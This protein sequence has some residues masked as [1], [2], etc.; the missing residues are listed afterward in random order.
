MGWKV[1]TA[2]RSTAQHSTGQH[3]WQPPAHAS[4]PF[5]P[6][7]H[8]HTHTHHNHNHWQGLR[9]LL[10]VHPSAPLFIAGHSLGGALATLCAVDVR[11][12][13]AAPDV[14]LFTFGSPRVGN[15]VFAAW[16]EQQTTVCIR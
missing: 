2:L 1:C 9:Y 13:L 4:P 5:P 3:V 8:T 11:A 15:A 10:S 12:R 14:R 16:V 7:P 6:P